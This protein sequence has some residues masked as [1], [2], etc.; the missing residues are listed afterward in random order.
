MYEPTKV[1]LPDGNMSRIQVWW[2]LNSIYIC[3]ANNAMQYGDLH[4]SGL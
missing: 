2:S 3:N 1:T 4:N